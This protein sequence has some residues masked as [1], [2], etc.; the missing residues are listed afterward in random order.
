MPLIDSVAATSVGLVDGEPLLD[1][2][3]EEDSRAEVDMNVVMTG[4]GRFVEMQATAEGQPFDGENST[5]C[6][7]WPPAAFAAYRAAADAG[8]G[9]FQ[10]PTR[11][12]AVR[13]ATAT[14]P[15]RLLVA[16]SNPGKL[17]RI[18]RT[19]WRQLRGLALDMDLLPRFSELAAV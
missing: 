18:S 1:L 7:R 5:S 3:Y 12:N 13:R 4:S 17:A 6:W 8:A 11:A 2:C 9:E 19:G 16:S 15:L 14:G 10:C